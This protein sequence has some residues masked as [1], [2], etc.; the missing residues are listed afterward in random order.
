MVKRSLKGKAVRAEI[1]G[2]KHLKRSLPLRAV[3]AL[4]LALFLGVG[5]GV[6]VAG[7][8]GEDAALDAA[9]SSP[10]FD[11][12]NVVGM[13][14]GRARRALAKAGYDV[15]IVGKGKV[16]LQELG[17]EGQLLRLEGEKGEGQR[18]CD[19][20]ESRCVPVPS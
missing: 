20:S 9:A 3:G 1:G 5:L 6:A 15:M 14:M 12:P 19:A 17:F 10:E 13:P 8:Q 18:Y 16:V 2:M 4:S 11:S 7:A